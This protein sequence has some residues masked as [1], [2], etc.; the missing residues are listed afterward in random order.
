M[1]EQLIKLYRYLITGLEPSMRRHVFDY[2]L[3]T[4][5]ISLTRTSFICKQDIKPL[6]PDN[7]LDIE[8][9]TLK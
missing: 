4:P 6:G 2:N 9:I 3:N 8:A 7:I 1:G 5:E